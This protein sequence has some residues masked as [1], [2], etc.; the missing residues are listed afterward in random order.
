MT[1][2]GPEVGDVGDIHGFLVFESELPFCSVTR[3]SI[4]ECRRRRGGGDFL[5]IENP[6]SKFEIPLRRAGL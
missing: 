5:E 1:D 4:S 6:E 3:F 2:E